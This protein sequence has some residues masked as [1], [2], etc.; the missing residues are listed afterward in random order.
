MKSVAKLHKEFIG[1]KIEDKISIQKLAEKF[2][3]GARNDTN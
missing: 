2:M 3:N 1:S